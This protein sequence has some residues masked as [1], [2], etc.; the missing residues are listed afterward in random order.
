MGVRLRRLLAP[1]TK[2]SPGEW[3][4]ETASGY[5]AMSCP[6]CGAIAELDE[7]VVSVG[8]D[9]RPIFSCPSPA[10]PFMDFVELSA[11]NDEAAA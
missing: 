11:W 6:C 9:V 7:H 10:C 2:L 3:S 1:A 5:P 4:A 8:G